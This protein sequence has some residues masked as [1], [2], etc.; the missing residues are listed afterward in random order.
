M[1]TE[2][3]KQIPKKITWALYSDVHVGGQGGVEFHLDPEKFLAHLQE[4]IKEVDLIILNGDIYDLYATNCCQSKKEKIKA[5]ATN[6][7]KLWSWVQTQISLGKLIYIIGNHDSLKSTEDTTQQ[8]MSIER[9]T[10]QIFN[11]RV[12]VEHGHFYDKSE[13]YYHTCECCCEKCPK[14]P[15]CCGNFLYALKTFFCCQ[16]KFTD[17]DY[18]AIAEQLLKDRDLVVFGHTHTAMVVK[19][20]NKHYVNTGTCCNSTFQFDE[21]LITFTEKRIDIQQNKINLT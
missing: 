16:K 8:L 17:D 12:L 19:M 2:E 6:Y 11:W 4:R 18:E 3:T 13:Q 15:R 7:D 14:C 1:S 10:T 5:I 9:Y 21:T 20:G